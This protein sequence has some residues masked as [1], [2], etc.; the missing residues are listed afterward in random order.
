MKTYLGGS[1]SVF[2]ATTR[3]D[4]FVKH[5]SRSEAGTRMM[6]INGKKLVI[7]GISAGLMDYFL[8]E[9]ELRKSKW[10]AAK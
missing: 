10:H 1:I 7:F 2:D 5:E 9:E 8:F 4:R 6:L 3:S